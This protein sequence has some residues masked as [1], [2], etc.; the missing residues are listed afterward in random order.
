MIKV[1]NWKEERIEKS[2]ILLFHGLLPWIYTGKNIFI[3]YPWGSISVSI[4]LHFTHSPGLLKNIKILCQGESTIK[5]RS[6][7]DYTGRVLDFS[8]WIYPNN[9]QTVCWS[10]CQSI[11]NQPFKCCTFATPNPYLWTVCINKI[12]LNQPTFDSLLTR[13]A[14]KMCH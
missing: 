13:L 12:C 5:S 2:R 10:C 11:H 3:L 14:F 1:K 4:S 8:A 9:N 6:R 7:P